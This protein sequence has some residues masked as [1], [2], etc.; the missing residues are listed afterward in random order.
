MLHEEKL[1]SDSLKYVISQG[2]EIG[3][4]S[5]LFGQVEVDDTGKAVAVHVAGDVVKVGGGEMVWPSE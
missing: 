3:Q 4:P 2:T 1:L 5:Q